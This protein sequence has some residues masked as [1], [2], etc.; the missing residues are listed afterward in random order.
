VAIIDGFDE[1]SILTVNHLGTGAGAFDTLGVAKVI[2]R[3]I[4]KNAVTT[5]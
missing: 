2:D 1:D 3:A 4:H 5:A